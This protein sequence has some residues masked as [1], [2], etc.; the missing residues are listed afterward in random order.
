MKTI[1]MPTDKYDGTTDPENHCTTFEKHIMMYTDSDS[2]WCKV[3]LSTLL[4]EEASWYKGLE[5]GSIYSFRQLQ[6]DF[7]ACFVSKQKRKMLGELMSFL[8][9]YRESLRDYLTSFNNESITNSNLQ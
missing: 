3:L 2:M 8:Q 6:V 7:M 5:A 4:D 1:K 9:K